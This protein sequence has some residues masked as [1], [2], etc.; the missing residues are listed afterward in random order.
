M[1]PYPLWFKVATLLT[2]PAAVFYSVGYRSV[3]AMGRT[4]L[5]ET[6]VIVAS[7]DRQGARVVEKRMCEQLDRSDR[8][9]ASC[10]F[11]LS[12]VALKLPTV[13]PQ[14]SV[15][16]VVQKIADTITELTMATLRRSLPSAN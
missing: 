8:L 15:A 4:G 6:L 3:Y 9:R 1:L 5:G 2:I 7:T 12:S 13:D 16:K 11:K 14:E 10:I